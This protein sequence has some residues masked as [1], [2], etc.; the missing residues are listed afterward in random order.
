MADQLLLPPAEDGN[1]DRVSAAV[2]YFYQTGTTTPVTV[3]EEDGT[4]PLG[5]SVV[6]DANGVFAQVFTISGTGIKIDV[7]TPLGAS[8]PGYPV[9]P[10]IRVA[11]ANSQAAQVSYAPSVLLPE[12]NVQDAIDEL[13]DQ[14][15]STAAN[16]FKGNNT[17]STGPVLDLTAAQARALIGFSQSLA[18]PAGY[19]RLPGGLIQQWQTL[20]TSAGG[21]VTWT[22]PIA[23][24]AGCYGGHVTPI[25]NAFG[26]SGQFDSTPSVTQ[27]VVSAWNGGSRAAVLVRISVL[28]W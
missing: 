26:Y 9:D 22:L 15:L 12:T 7:K 21:G 4:T 18:A 25:N 6:A 5:T 23:F 19:I 1:G 17:G 27:A 10:A 28:G 20:T 14:T 2:A 16:T 13:A 3:Y 11:T 24:P 8:L